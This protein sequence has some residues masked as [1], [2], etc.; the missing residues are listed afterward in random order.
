M[1]LADAIAAA[2]ARGLDRLDAQLLLLHLL[3][4]AYTDRAWLLAHDTELLA[5][6]AQA[7]FLELCE[8]RAR[9][10]PLAYIVGHKEFFGLDLHVDKRVLVPRPETEIV[11]EWA[12][13]LIPDDGH[14][15]RVVDLGCG[16]GAIALAIKRARPHVPVDAVDCSEGALEV[17][18]ANARR[19]SLEVN[20]AQACWLAASDRRYD[21]IVANPPY[22][23]EADPHL[24]AL[25]HEPL[26]AL[27]AGRDGL[28][29][30][31]AISGQ[32]AAHLRPGGW[33]LLEHGWDQA[34]SVR[35]LL[36]A[37]GL[38][39]VATRRDLAGIERCSGGKSP[40]LG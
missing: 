33:L 23:A 32:A 1:T 4:R 9:Q 21:L 3:G 30:I 20:F 2:A 13:E 8:R 19:L 28:R 18:T 7:A 12:L 6:S 38:Q 24:A 34:E 40:E 39:H 35:G 14:S 17:A 31:R 25:R 29:E 22:V 10:E 5:A 15:L 26:L 36:A 37:A 16:S 11:V 27:A